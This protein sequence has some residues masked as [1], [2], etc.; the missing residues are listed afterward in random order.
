MHLDTIYCIAA[1]KP[2][3]KILLLSSTVIKAGHRKMP[4]KANQSCSLLPPALR[5]LPCAG[6]SWKAWPTSER[7]AC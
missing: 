7:D 5:Q 3:R 2:G 6:P 4:L 1:L